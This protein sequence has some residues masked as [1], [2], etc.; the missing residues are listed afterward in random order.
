M[1]DG[2]NCERFSEI[3]YELAAGELEG[4]EYTRAMSHMNSCPRCK[5]EFEACKELLEALH[6]M[7]EAEAPPELLENVMS[8]ISEESASSPKIRR[9]NPLLIRFG[10]TAA[11]ALLLIAGVVYVMPKINNQGDQSV[12]EVEQTLNSEIADNS[13]PESSYDDIVAD[14]PDIDPSESTATPGDVAPVSENEPAADAPSKVDENQNKPENTQNRQASENGSDTEKNAALPEKSETKASSQTNDAETVSDNAETFSGSTEQSGIIPRGIDSNES[15]ASPPLTKR[16]SDVPEENGQEDMQEAVNAD[17]RSMTT[18]QPTQISM[19]TTDKT[20]FSENTAMGD[21]A[22]TSPTAGSSSSGGS[23]SRIEGGHSGGGGGGSGGGSG[24][25]AARKIA[26]I[27][28]F[29]VDQSYREAA[30]A[31]ETKGKTMSQIEA[32][33]IELEIPYSIKIRNEDYT[34]EYTLAGPERRAEIDRLC[35]SDSCEITYE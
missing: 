1:N 32:R 8:K 33:L 35:A 13:Q 2:M 25:T 28:E 16:R 22:I 3:A 34:S 26:R 21:N 29:K 14:T 24:G 7:S 20:V 6:S 5:K 9:L 23:D 18:D 15:T 4:E 12:S 19:P 17:T 27:V 30:M 10:T 11:A 31:V